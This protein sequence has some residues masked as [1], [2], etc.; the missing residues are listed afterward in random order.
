MYKNNYYE[1]ILFRVCQIDLLH[2]DGSYPNK[3]CSAIIYPVHKKGDVKI[4]N[5]YRGI[6]LLSCISKL[7]TTIV[8]NRLVEWADKNENLFD[9]QAGLRKGKGTIDNIFVL[10]CLVDKYL[11]K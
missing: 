10:Q 6:S 1:S 4:P 9:I 11:G 5:N 8:N 3:W 2:D 7:F